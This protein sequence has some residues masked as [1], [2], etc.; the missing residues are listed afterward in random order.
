MWSP[1]SWISLVSRKGKNSRE[2]VSPFFRR[3]P[4]M[5]ASL[6]SLWCRAPGGERREEK[7]GKRCI[8]GDL[9]KLHGFKL[10]IF[11]GKGINVLSTML[12]HCILNTDEKLT[13]LN[14]WENC[15]H[16]EWWIPILTTHPLW[17][18]DFYNEKEAQ[19]LRSSVVDTG[20]RRDNG[21]THHTVIGLWDV[22]TF[23]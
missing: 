15:F 11:F 22:H 17:F 13:I 21:W 9:V 20:W 12:S 19:S 1:G 18:S 2:A 8:H 23:H 3:L 6:Q 4:L 16:T 10:P 7:V 14:V 5:F